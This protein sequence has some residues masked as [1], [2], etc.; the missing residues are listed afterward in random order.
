MTAE[1][2]IEILK[3]GLLRTIEEHHLSLD[4][5]VFM[6]D[7]DPK[8]TAKVTKQWLKVN[9][10]KVLDWPPQSPDI[11]PI[12]NLWSILDKKI[13]KQEKKPVNVEELWEILQKEWYKIDLEIIRNLY[14]SMTS[15]VDALRRNHGGYTKY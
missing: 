2:Y 9:K 10:I 3:T 14:I 6:H 13:R 1:R 7:N 15:R 8:H 4:N 12:E 11:N 5:V